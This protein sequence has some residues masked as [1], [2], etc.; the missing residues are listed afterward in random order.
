MN[1]LPYIQHLDHL[2]FSWCLRRKH[3]QLAIKVS[4]C[5]S[6]T[7]DGPLYALIGLAFLFDANWSMAKLLAV[8]FFV[9]RLCYLCAKTGFKRNRPPE[10][11]PGFQ[12]AIIPSDKFSF[13]SGHTSAAFFMACALSSWYPPL[14]WI[15]Y[16]WA[17]CVG[18][19]RVMLGVHFPTDTLAGALMGHTIC[20]LF[21]NAF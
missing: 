10:A 19:A 21:L 7:A 17:M 16:P 6:F 20:L 5:V 15:L 13:P 1:L 18:S 14:A 9:E 8:G 4:R 12:S 11:I 2:T 3:R